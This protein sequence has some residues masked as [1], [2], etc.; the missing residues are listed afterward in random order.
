MSYSQMEYASPEA[1]AYNQTSRQHSNELQ[2]TQDSTIRSMD[3]ANQPSPKV[4][5]QGYSIPPAN[6]SLIPESIGEGAGND[7]FFDDENQR[8][9][10]KKYQMKWGVN[11]NILCF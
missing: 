7:G 3:I 8:Y 1:Q 9:R 5:E 6:R 4:D 11:A 10:H 2:N